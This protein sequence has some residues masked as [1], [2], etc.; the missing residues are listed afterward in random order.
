MSE[1]A[2]VERA[3]RTSRRALWGTVLV[4]AVIAG[5]LWRNATRLSAVEGRLAAQADTLRALEHQKSALEQRVHSLNDAPD[6]GVRA[7]RHRVENIASVQYDFFLWIDDAQRTAAPI[8]EVRYSS[9]AWADSVRTSTDARTGFAVFRRA[10]PPPCPDSTRVTVILAN[11]STL[12]YPVDLCQAT[13]IGN[14]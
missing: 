11:D 7:A 14:R 5:L 9:P 8:R 12:T 4:V 1:D 13:T 6:G 3:R 10:P 2:I